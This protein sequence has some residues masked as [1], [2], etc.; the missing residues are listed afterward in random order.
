M[1]VTVTPDQI[2][3]AFEAVKDDPSFNESRA[4]WEYL[5][6][7][8]GSHVEVRAARRGEKRRLQELATQNA[9]LALEQDAAEGERRRLRRVEALAHP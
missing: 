5:S 1:R 6:E 7:L 2:R 3:S 9:E 8:R 4:L